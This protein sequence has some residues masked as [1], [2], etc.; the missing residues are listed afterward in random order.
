M[1]IPPIA[2]LYIYLRELAPPVHIVDEFSIVGN[3]ITN[4]NQII[5]LAPIF[6]HTA[7]GHDK[8]LNK[9]LKEYRQNRI[10]NPNYA[11]DEIITLNQT[12]PNIDIPYIE[13]EI[14]YDNRTSSYFIHGENRPMCVNTEYT[15][16]TFAND[17]TES[18]FAS[19]AIAQATRESSQP[20]GAQI[21]EGPIDSKH[22]LKSVT[23]RPV[24]PHDTYQ[25]Q[26]IRLSDFV[27]EN[28]KIDPTNKSARVFIACNER[29]IF[30][31][32]SK[33][34]LT[35]LVGAEHEGELIK[36]QWKKDQKHKIVLPEPK[37][38]RIKAE[39]PIYLGSDV[40]VIQKP[41]SNDINKQ[42]KINVVKPLE[43]EETEYKRIMDEIQA[44]VTKRTKSKSQ[45]INKDI[46]N[47]YDLKEISG[48]VLSKS[49]LI[50]EQSNFD[51]YHGTE[52]HLSTPSES[53]EYASVI[54]K[55]VN[56]LLVLSD[57]TYKY[58]C[59]IKN[60]LSSCKYED[61]QIG[62]YVIIHNFNISSADFVDTPEIKNMDDELYIGNKNQ[63][64]RQTIID[65]FASQKPE[66]MKMFGFIDK[67]RHNEKAPFF[68]CCN[69][70]SEILQLKDEQWNGVKEIFAKH[71]TGFDNVVKTAITA[72]PR[73]N[74][75]IANSEDS[76]NVEFPPTP[77]LANDF[78]G[79]YKNLKPSMITKVSNNFEV[80]STT[81]SSSE[82][83]SVTTSETE[84]T[85]NDDYNTYE[86][87]S[88]SS[89]GSSY[90]KSSM[91]YVKNEADIGSVANGMNHTQRT[92]VRR[93]NPDN[94]YMKSST[95]L[96]PCIYNSESLEANIAE[97]N[98]SS[99]LNI[100]PTNINNSKDY[101]RELFKNL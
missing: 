15:L 33:E 98:Y 10:H 18:Q 36:M 61:I 28:I 92:Q 91:R 100:T 42:I 45:N 74:V 96:L 99:N 51:K 75:Y 70:Y 84:T 35:S 24:R 5:V 82:L 73:S 79:S 47:I 93:F 67:L 8:E 22:E 53:S 49:S 64:T 40:K 52:L 69:K 4:E 95:K 86:E 27:I 2:P 54:H 46:E 87:T 97:K 25:S 23:H 76:S 83:P 60:D 101:F 17:Y 39:G 30:S 71:F 81:E 63:T 90:L 9:R 6:Q 65:N 85:T 72:G 34:E 20:T 68:I 77:S 78:V 94:P 7:A 62:D 37:A 66:C 11:N 3:V 14:R 32:M 56:Y 21:L 55:D 44:V 38:H 58:S 59:L 57:Q 31:V 43:D 50:T 12:K 80:Q 13:C 26:C 89:F 48:F 19:T 1:K 41:Q 16:R 88:F 29:S